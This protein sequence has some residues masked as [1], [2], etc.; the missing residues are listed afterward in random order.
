VEEIGSPTHIK[1]PQWPEEMTPKGY[2]RR[3]A[4]RA[5]EPN[6]SG[7]HAPRVPRLDFKR[8]HQA[9]R[10]Q[11]PAGTDQGVL[12]SASSISTSVSGDNGQNVTDSATSSSLARVEGA[13]DWSSGSQASPQKN[14]LLAVMEPE[15]GGDRQ[16][17]QSHPQK[18]Q[19]SPH[20]EPLSS[21]VKDTSEMRFSPY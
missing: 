17:L 7:L 8:L 21:R 10:L 9:P 4:W 16:G 6:L 18:P 12:D 14:K 20:K 11:R 5:S 1:A 2:R 15:E 13:A 19:K 3:Q